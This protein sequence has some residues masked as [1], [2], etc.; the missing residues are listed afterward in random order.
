MAFH[1]AQTHHPIVFAAWSLCVEDAIQAL[2]NGLESPE[3]DAVFTGRFANDTRCRTRMMRLSRAVSDSY[4]HEPV[5][6]RLCGRSVTAAWLEFW[7]TL[8]SVLTA[9]SPTQFLYAR[10]IY[11]LFSDGVLSAEDRDWL[12]HV[13]FKHDR[14][15]VLALE[16]LEGSDATVDATVCGCPM[17]GLS[18][19]ARWC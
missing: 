4:T 16:N 18:V 8:G 6:C 11:S 15:L 12:F 10:L 3:P 19:C 7:S 14:P 1:L 9:L 17:W 13:L 2:L 5:L